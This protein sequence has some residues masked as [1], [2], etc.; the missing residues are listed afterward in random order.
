VPDLLTPQLWMGVL[1]VCTLSTVQSSIGFTSIARGN[2]PA[3][4]CGAT[5]SN[6]LGIVITPL[7]VTLLLHRHHEANGLSQV[8]SILLQLLLPFVLGNLMRRWI[9]DWINRHK[10]IVNV[11]DRGGILLSVYAAFSV[12]VAQGVWHLFPPGQL[13]LLVLVN[14]VLLGAVLLITTYGARALKMPRGDE[15][16]LV[17]CGS[18]KSLASGIPIASVLF[19]GSGAAV[20]LLPI[21]LFH[22]MQLM[23]CAVLA[24][25]YAAGVEDAEPQRLRQQ[26][27]GAAGDLALI[28]DHF[29]SQAR[30]TDRTLSV[31]LAHDASHATR[32]DQSLINKKRKNTMQTQVNWFE[33]ATK[34]LPR[35]TRFY[36]AVFAT[37]CARSRSP[38]AVRWPSSCVTTAVHRLPD[39]PRLAGADPP[40]H[41]D[42]SRCR[43]LD[44]GG[45]RPR[46]RRRWRAH[47]GTH[48]LPNDIG[49]IAQFIDSEGNRLA[50]HAMH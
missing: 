13:A 28:A 20:V 30:A 34:D 24:R 9:G 16:V 46:G 42:L 44:P 4:I 38:I 15:I 11:V 27:A 43:P 33:I 39:R 23:L 41:T 7:L 49:Y 25:R 47:H 19:A 29:S 17:F 37:S 5:A 10:V 1:F 6:L 21:M 8:L 2:V 48:Q 35:A 36:E 45:A 26:E 50:L 3:A 32:H 40:G 12:A 31:A 18:K 14:A 22:Q